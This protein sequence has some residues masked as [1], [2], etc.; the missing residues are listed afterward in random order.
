MKL[1]FINLFLSFLFSRDIFADN[2]NSK[3]KEIFYTKIG[4]CETKD[5][6]FNTA[7]FSKIPLNRQRDDLE[8]Y[9]Q[10]ILF[11]H[12]SGE[13]T[14][15]AQEMGLIS[16]RQTNDGEVC[17]YRPFS[18]TKKIIKSFWIELE[19]ELSIEK[20]GTIIKIRDDFPWL[21]FSL[22]MDKNFFEVSARDK[23]F[24][25]GKVQ[26]NFNHEDLNVARICNE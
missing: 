16:C 12:S 21:G 23:S 9:L 26:V 6:S 24:I 11:L 4:S 8:L 17:G 2:V 18:D 7:R 10:L 19:N 15:R 3:F 1:A 20:I 22:K 14:L 25:G 5:L 13:V